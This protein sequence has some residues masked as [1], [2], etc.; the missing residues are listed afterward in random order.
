MTGF[1]SGGLQVD[2]RETVATY[3]QA[4]Y[5]TGIGELTKSI[6][7]PQTSKSDQGILHQ[8]MK[9]KSIMNPHYKTNYN[10]MS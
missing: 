10:R 3:T 7:S 5:Q 6:L 8:F 9:Y 1:S 2:R 4:Y